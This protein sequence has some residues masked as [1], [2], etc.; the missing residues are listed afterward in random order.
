MNSYADIDGLPVAADPGLLAD[1]LRNSGGLWF[2]TTAQW[3]FF[4]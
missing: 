4:G 1:L 3:C 2:R